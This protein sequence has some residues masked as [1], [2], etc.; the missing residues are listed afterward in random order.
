MKRRL[1]LLLPLVTLFAGWIFLRRPAAAEGGAECE[2]GSGRTTVTVRYSAAAAA[3]AAEEAER[4]FAAE[5][6]RRAPVS[7]PTFRLLLRGEAV[8][9]LLAEEVNGRTR[10]TTLQSRNDL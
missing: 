3:A 1:L 6:W 8:V 9:A 4:A 2:V 5:G 10:I 7:T